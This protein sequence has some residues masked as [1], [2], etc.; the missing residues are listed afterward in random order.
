MSNRNRG[1]TGKD[2]IETMNYIE[3]EYIESALKRLGYTNKVDDTE[4]KR[5]DLEVVPYKKQ[6]SK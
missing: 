1:L 5:K 3:D 4:R 6:K 2:I